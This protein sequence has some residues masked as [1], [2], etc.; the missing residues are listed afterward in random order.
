MKLIKNEKGAALITALS[1]G[2]IGSLFVAALWFLVRQDS[3]IVYDV[4]IY[5]TELEAAKGV[6]DFVLAQID[7]GTLE[8]SGSDCKEKCSSD[9][10]NLKIDLDKDLC[11]AVGKTDCDSITA[12]YI[13]ESSY[14]KPLRNSSGEVNNITVYLQTISIISQNEK[15]LGT[16]PH[17]AEINIVYES[18]N[19]SPSWYE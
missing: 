1:L 4:N 8:C 18:Q 11:K 16:I 19:P 10:C 14:L 17:Q 15:S 2:L 5:N 13:G 12:S 9:S 3:A 6:S 7:A